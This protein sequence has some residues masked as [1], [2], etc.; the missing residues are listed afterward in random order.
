VNPRQPSS[1]PPEKE[2]FAPQL[3][4]SRAVGLFFAKYELD[5]IHYL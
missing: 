1:K 5:L 4:T 2:Y 3:T